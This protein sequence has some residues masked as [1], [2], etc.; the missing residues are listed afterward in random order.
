MT[1]YKNNYPS[2]GD[3]V[4]VKIFEYPEK[5]NSILCSLVEYNDISGMILCTEITKRKETDSKKIFKLDTFIPVTVIVVDDE[6]KYNIKID[7]S[8][9]KLNDQEKIKELEK[10]RYKENIYNL[11]IEMSK[12]CNIELETVLKYTLW[13]FM[14]NKKLVNEIDIFYLEILESPEIFIHYFPDK[15]SVD[16]KM[17][18]ENLKSRISCSEE[19][20]SKNL[21][22]VIFEGI[23]N[24]S[25]LETLKYCLTNN[26]NSEIKCIS[27][28]KYNISFKSLIKGDSS[29][30]ILTIEN[31]IREN[32]KNVKCKFEF[33][34]ICKIV[35]KQY[36]LKKYFDEN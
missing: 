28:S 15:Y 12:I 10:F 14:E 6:D 7:L 2:V 33:D 17:F 5:G 27:P 11:A 4:V 23:N 31:I 8:Y 18:V 29:K 32:L 26:I 21:L 35:E 1:F 36:V 13:K 24:M 19:I 20:A 3:T 30:N 25:N 16:A 34:P 22:L 9:I